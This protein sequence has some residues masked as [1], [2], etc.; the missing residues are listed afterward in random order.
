MYA[1]QTSALPFVLSCGVASVT[2]V[3]AGTVLVT[4]SRGAGPRG[5]SVSTIG[6]AKTEVQFYYNATF[7]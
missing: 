1:T 4:V 5:F 3:L 2:K 6:L 7:V